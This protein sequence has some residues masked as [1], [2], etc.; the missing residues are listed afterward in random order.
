[1]VILIQPYMQFTN[2]LQILFIDLPAVNFEISIVS[3]ICQEGI[4]QLGSR[5]LKGAP[6]H[7]YN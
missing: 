3:N 1:M 6:L 7:W 5:V 2:Y 4:K